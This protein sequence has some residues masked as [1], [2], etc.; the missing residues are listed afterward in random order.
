MNGALIYRP[1]NRKLTWLAF[2]GAITID[3]AAIAIAENRSKP[4]VLISWVEPEGP[5]EGFDTLP[6]PEEE[7]EILPPP[8]MIAEDQEFREENP[9][10]PPIRPRKKTPVTAVR[11]TNIGTGPAIHPGS[12]KALTLYAPKPSYP[13]EA[14]RGGVIGSGV[15]QLTVNSAVGNVIDARMSQSTGSAI[16]DTA[17]VDALLRWRFKPGVAPSVDVPITYTLSG[18]S[19]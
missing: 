14:R 18:V 8:Q 3:L 11:S 1:S 9:A 19:Y 15:A 13:Y 4:A 6:P 7:P 2:V 10:R 12:V 5:V 16:L 17:T